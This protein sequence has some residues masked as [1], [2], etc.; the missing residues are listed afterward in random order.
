MEINAKT[1]S[2]LFEKLL[3]QLKEFGLDARDWRL[4]A[5]ADGRARLVHRTDRSF[6][7]IG[8][9]DSRRGTWK[10]LRLENL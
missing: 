2:H 9:I 3:A 1:Q 5:R 7:F 6:S 8:A 10:Q 4:I